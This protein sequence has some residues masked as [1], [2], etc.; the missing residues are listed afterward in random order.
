MSFVFIAQVK[1]PSDSSYLKTLTNYNKNNEGCFSF[2]E[3]DSSITLF[4]NYFQKNSNGNIGHPSSSLFIKYNP[5]TIGF[6]LY[7]APY[8]NDMINSDSIKYYQT[9]GPYANLTG[10]A[11]TKKEQVFKFLYS[12]T[13]KNKLNITLAFNRYSA[14]GFYKNQQSFTNNFYTSF[15]YKSKTN[16]VG[17]Y[18]YILFNKLKHQEN[19]GLYNDSLFI[20]NIT[21]NKSLIPVNLTTAKREYRNT[22]FDFNPWYRINKKEDSTTVFSHFIDYQLNYLGNFTKYYDTKS[23]SNDFYN[24]FYLDTVYSKD[25]THWQT[26][27]NQLNYTLKYNQIGSQ[28]KIGIKNEYN[29]VHQFSDSLF[30]NT[31][32]NT[33]VF[34]SNNKYSG[35]ITANYIFNG[36]Y[37][38]DYVIDISNQIKQTFLKL[39]LKLFLKANI[40]KRH[41]DYIYNTWLSNHFAWNN[42]FKPVNKFQSTFSIT[43]SRNTLEL[44][45]IYQSIDH[46]IYFNNQAIPLQTEVNI[47][48]ISAF[49]NK[50]FLLFK[51][52]GVN[53]SYYY[54]T[55]S[56]KALISIPSH[57]INGALYYQGNLFKNA[58]QLQVGLN[59]QYFSEFYGYAYMPA[60]N[61]YY[62]QTQ[63]LVG[64]YPFVDFFLNARIK[65]VKVFLKI[66]HL[67]QGFTG[68][69]YSL[70]P[71]YYQ[72]DRAFKFGINWLFFD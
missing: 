24:V 26:I 23:G 62:V 7:S 71:G 32:L 9:K 53:A 52:L 33:G 49:A 64:N 18:S 59:V 8:E 21:I 43:T 50:N 48:N 47:Q 6:N 35:F 10:I 16:R 20:N 12:N 58:L 36:V 39:P 1:Y 27:R 15:N 72:N 60:T 68:Y 31:S 70:T 40:E 44:G 55:S 11:G 41:P 45:I 66:D 67:N 4:Q 5:K 38:N 56:Y 37:K 28:L 57:I 2:S 22:T 13:F 65:P 54:Q 19:G 69:K 30:F 17:F 3:I 42:N 25:S 29:K 34:V 61:Q 14:V 46:F 63:N 51:H